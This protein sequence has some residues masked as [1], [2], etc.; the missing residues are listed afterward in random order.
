MFRYIYRKLATLGLPWRKKLIH[1]LENGSHRLVYSQGKAG[2]WVPKEQAARLDQYAAN[3]DQNL[4]L[5]FEV[6]E[7]KDYTTH[8]FDLDSDEYWMR[9]K[10]EEV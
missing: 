8:Y 3:Y 7:V 6:K 4:P 2:E 1:E 9:S 10:K 5:V